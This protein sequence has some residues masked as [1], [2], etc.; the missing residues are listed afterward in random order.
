MTRQHIDCSCLY[1]N[2]T[3]F[4]KSC[5]TY[6]C[7]KHTNTSHTGS[8]QHHEPVNVMPKIGWASSTLPTKLGGANPR[9]M[10]TQ[11]CGW[12]PTPLTTTT[13]QAQV[14]HQIRSSPEN[15]VQITTE[16]QELLYKGVIVKTTYTTELSVLNFSGCLPLDS[17]S[18]RPSTLSHLPMKRE[19]LHVSMPTI[20]SLSSTQEGVHKIAETSCGLPETKWLSSHNVPRWHANAT[21]VQGPTTTGDPTYLPIIQ[22]LGVSGEP[23]EICT[24]SNSGDRVSGLPSVL[25]N[26]GALDSLEKLRKIQRMPGICWIENMWQWGK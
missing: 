24:N 10:G 8:H 22:V 4:I 11:N 16:V 15:K 12:I 23:E 2:A 5:F 19:D 25:S 26:Y 21:S 1:T 7:D 20:W 9:S 3:K 14:P 13:Y 18:P 6:S 17:Y